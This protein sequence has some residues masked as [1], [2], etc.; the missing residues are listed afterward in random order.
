MS[1]PEISVLLVGIG[2][3]ARHHAKVLAGLGISFCALSPS[4][5]NAEQFA[6]EFGVEVLTGPV[7]AQ[8]DAVM[9]RFSH[10]IIVTPVTALADAT[11]DLVTHGVPNILVEKPGAITPGELQTLHDDC[12]GKADIYIAY[13]RRFYASVLAAEKYIAEDGGVISALFEFS[14]FSAAIAKIGHDPR[15]LESWYYANS[16]HVTDMAFSLIGSPVKL[17]AFVDGELD[18]H[19]TAARFAGH[20]KSDKGVMFNYFAE[21]DSAP[22]WQVIL[23]TGSRALIF[24]PLEALRYRTRDGFEEFE[25]EL[26]DDLDSRY[27]AGLYRQARA[28]LYGEDRGRLMTLRDNLDHLA[29]HRIIA[30]GGKFERNHG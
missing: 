25:V 23:Y 9:D 18:W 15:V 30:D 1:V 20:G 14:E 6:G 8:T 16:T 19:P 29:F 27:K 12:D 24:Q 13:N 26:P 3:M 21:W 4:G 11:R 2:P 10:A 28:F 17:D 7:L 5:Q 22:R